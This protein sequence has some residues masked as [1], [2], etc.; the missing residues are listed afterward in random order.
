MEVIWKYLLVDKKF[1]VYIIE[2]HWIPFHSKN[3]IDTILS[4]ERWLVFKNI[5]NR[6]NIKGKKYFKNSYWE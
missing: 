4:S 3:A 1:R 2:I 5:G 6:R